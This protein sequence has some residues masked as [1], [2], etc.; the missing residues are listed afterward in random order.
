MVMLIIEKGSAAAGERYVREFA[1]ELVHG[2]D[3]LVTVVLMY[4]DMG[5]VRRMPGRH[6][7]NRYRYLTVL[8]SLVDV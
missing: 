1:R 6:G 3:T 5:N 7:D 8:L 4:R 2:M